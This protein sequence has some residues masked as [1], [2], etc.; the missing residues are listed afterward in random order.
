MALTRAS[1]AAVLSQRTGGWTDDIGGRFAESLA[2]AGKGYDDPLGFALRQCGVI[3]ADVFVPNDADLASVAPADIDKVLD[4]AEYRLLVT[5]LQNFV[6]V[7]VTIGPRHESADQ[8]RKRLQEAVDAR[9]VYLR[10][11]YGYGAES[12]G[13]A[14]TLKAGTLS[15]DF[16]ES[17]MRQ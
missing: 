15:L 16:Q 14:A 2:N 8:M 7:D 13:D 1:L 9:A 11:A 3:P 6:D 10:A 12:T 4:F 17:I 5:A